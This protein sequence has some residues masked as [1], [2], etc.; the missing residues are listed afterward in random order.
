MVEEI[1]YLNSIHLQSV[2]RV[3]AVPVKALKKGDRVMFNFGEVNIVS[4]IKKISSLSHRI[5]WIGKNGDLYVQSKR[6]NTLMARI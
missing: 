5:T 3:P 6:S 2:G 4:K 1:D